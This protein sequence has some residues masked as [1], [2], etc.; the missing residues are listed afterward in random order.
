MTDRAPD[1]LAGLILAAGEG[2]RAGG[3][4]AL[5]V[6]SGRTWI[7]IAVRLLHEAG[8]D[9]IVVVLGAR[10]EEVRPLVPGGIA[11]VS[12]LVN[13]AWREGRTGSLQQGIRAIVAEAA[14]GGHGAGVPPRGLLVHQVDF[15]EVRSGTIRALRD[16]F[17]A[18]APN[19][20]GPE[21]CIFVPIEGGRRGHPILLGRDL[22]PE[23]CALGPDEPLH[24]VVRRAPRRVIELP[25][26]DPGIH[27]NRNE[28]EIEA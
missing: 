11:G 19:D 9:E 3:P 16:A 23:I 6:T 26:E 25:V 7:E 18:P 8:L 15:P 17:V 28:G 5:A 12:V 10:H 22:W 14:A 24:G 20:P 4:K 1:R 2:S 21:R 27:R 13:P